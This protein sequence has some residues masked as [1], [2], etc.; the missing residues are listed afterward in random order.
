MSWLILAS[1]THKPSRFFSALRFMISAECHG[2]RSTNHTILSMVLLNAIPRHRK[3]A[4]AATLSPPVAIKKLY[5]AYIFLSR[6]QARGI[7]SVW[8]DWDLLRI[9]SRRWRWSCLQAGIRYL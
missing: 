5:L 3:D 8:V 6:K 9:L 7:S 2:Y 4:C 1:R